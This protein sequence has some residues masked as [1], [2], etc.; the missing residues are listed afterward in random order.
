MINRFK[1]ES[2]ESPATNLRSRLNERNDSPNAS[3]TNTATIT[4]SGGRSRVLR[5][6]TSVITARTLSPVYSVVVN[7]VSLPARVVRTARRATQGVS[8]RHR[9]SLAG[10]WSQACTH[11]Q[12]VSAEYLAWCE[13]LGLRPLVHRKQWE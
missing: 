9:P 1:I 13:R 2:S 10:A 7:V 3:S 4:A 12:V 5:S 11:E 6:A 8:Y